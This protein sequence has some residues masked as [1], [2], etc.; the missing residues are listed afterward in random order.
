MDKVDSVNQAVLELW[1]NHFKENKEVLV[2]LIYPN[3]R[4]SGLLIIGLNP[5]FNPKL[6]QKNL[7]DSDHSKTSLKEFLLWNNLTKWLDEDN[8]VKLKDIEKTVREK[9]R[10]KSGY[11]GTFAKIAEDVG[12][13]NWEH[14]DLFF[15][16][17]TNQK[18]FLQ[19]I[20]N[21]NDELT[22][23]GKRQLNL[24]EELIVLAEPIVIIVANARASKIFDNKYKPTFNEEEGYH[25]I[26]SN[27]QKIPVFL[28]SMITRQRA[29]DE[30]SLRRL[31]W[32]IKKAI[33]K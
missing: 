3:I 30:Y 4:K 6:F 10:C 5:S 18:T 2:P 24:S 31:E 27:N 12:I 1:R 25:Q 21:R 32:H 29:I 13:N 7:D 19:Y 11:F 28:G 17:E 15:C 20:Y 26:K 22:D 33:E 14:I 9:G 16:R 23:F 8:F